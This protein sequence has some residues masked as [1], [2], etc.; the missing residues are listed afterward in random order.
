MSY[1]YTSYNSVFWISMN[2]KPKNH[3]NF[4]LGYFT[5]QDLGLGLHQ[6]QN[7][8]SISKDSEYCL[9]QP[10]AIQC[11]HC[12]NLSVRWVAGCLISSESIGNCLP[13]PSAMFDLDFWHDLQSKH[14]FLQIE[15]CS[16]HFNMHWYYS[17]S[18]HYLYCFPNLACIPCVHFSYLNMSN[19]L[20]KVKM[21]P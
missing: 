9:A 14:H 17:R 19:F 5:I 8:F 1:R 15:N 12:C 16:W 11:C 13:H 4:Y 3:L 18:Y 7:H 20:P 10:F 6:I 2:P 21:L